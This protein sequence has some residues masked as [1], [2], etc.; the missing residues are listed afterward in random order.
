MI[1]GYAIMLIGVISACAGYSMAIAWSTMHIIQ[2]VNFLP[3]M[4][5]YMPSSTVQ[6]CEGFDYNN[7]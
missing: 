3:M 7:L 4:M 1:L 5:I 6:F 2:F